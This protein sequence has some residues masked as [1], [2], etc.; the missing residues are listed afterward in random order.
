[1]KK[2]LLTILICSVPAGLLISRKGPPAEALGSVT[3]SRV[4]FYSGKHFDFG[5]CAPRG[6]PSHSFPNTI[7]HIYNY[8]AYSNW[9]GKHQDRDKWYT[10]RGKL[11]FGSK[12]YS[13]KG[14]GA[15]SDCGSL[16]IAGTSASGLLGKWTYKLY[17]DR[18]LV[19]TKTFTL[20]KSKA[21][22]GRIVVKAVKFYEGSRFDYA[23][24]A[25]HGPPS[26]SFSR[27]VK[28]INVLDTFTDWEGRHADRDRWYAPNGKLYFQSQP[29]K[30]V[31]SGPTK[32]CGQLN[33]AGT[34]A[35]H[36]PGRWT[37]RLIVDGHINNT[38]HFKLH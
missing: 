13:Y 37:Y 7:K 32:D 38:I 3:L 14:K 8:V 1:M 24:C 30:F 34:A 11:Y 5:S 9:Q 27:K 28:H 21:A 12:P 19:K 26:R 4:Q 20:V 18:H 10:P 31:G 23:S 6:K 36:M 22:P 16:R 2:L 17:V 33:V 35:Q 25:A 29:N 15:A